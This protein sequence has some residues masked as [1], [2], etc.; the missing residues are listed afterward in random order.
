MINDTFS[1]HSLTYR[2]IISSISIIHNKT[3]MS[4][5]KTT[6]VSI[7]IWYRKWIYT[8]ST[9]SN[10]T[11]FFYCSEWS[12]IL[13]VN[14]INN[15]KRI[16]FPIIYLISDTQTHTHFKL[17]N[18]IRS[19]IKRKWMEKKSKKSILWDCTFHVHN[20]YFSSNPQTG[21]YGNE[22][23]L[24]TKEITHKQAN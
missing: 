15:Q 18:I 10:L 24:K 21:K 13:I 14:I 9:Q 16:F 12:L 1:W 20:L 19:F 4:Y 3:K 8:K 17:L 5:A 23:R 2:T 22:I 11:N 7:S 6:Q